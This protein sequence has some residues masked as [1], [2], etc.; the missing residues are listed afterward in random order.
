M[1]T[2]PTTNLNLSRQEAE[3]DKPTGYQLVRTY[4]PKDIKATPLS[5]IPLILAAALCLIIYRPDC[6]SIVE[7]AILFVAISIL[8][9]V[10]HELL[11]ASCCY[12]LTRPHKFP[13]P[14]IRKCLPYVYLPSNSFLPKKLATI[15]LITPLVLLIPAALI[16]IV[17]V[18]NWFSIPPSRWLSLLIFIDIGLAQNDIDQILM[19]RREKNKML[20]SFRKTYNGIYAPCIEKHR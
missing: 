19:L 5:L 11:H 20:V 9:L 2:I 13:K 12:V 1:T 3:L 14:W 18:M 4:D 16:F 10:L 7:M 17:P 8:S 15:A 6:S